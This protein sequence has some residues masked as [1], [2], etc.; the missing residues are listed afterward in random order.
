MSLHKSK[1]LSSPVVIIAG[2]VEGL[3]PAPTDDDLTRAEEQEHLEEQRRLFYV[4]LT[5]VKAKP[6][7]GQPGTLVLTYSRSMSLAN[8]MQ[9][10]I[11]PASV[12]YGEARLLASR[13]IREL[14]PSAPARRAG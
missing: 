10:G 7:D 3:L 4:G 13:F 8:A 5:R 2:C 1:G 11:S 14:G 9:S 6:E 12:S